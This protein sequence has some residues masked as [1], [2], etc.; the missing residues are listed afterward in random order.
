[1]GSV[2]IFLGILVFSAHL[3][4]MI[5]SKKKIPDVLL[6]L[7]IGVLIG[8]VLN[9][10]SP[11]DFGSVGGVFTS[12]TLVVILFE[13]GTG[14]SIGDL[15][16]SWRSTV[17]LT[18]SSFVAAAVVVSAISYWFGND[19]LNSITIG[20]IL[21]GT[22]S[23]VVIPLAQHL[24]LST[25]TKTSLILESALT[26][27]LCIV[28]AFAFMNAKLMGSGLNVG[29]VAGNV[30][31]SFVLA[32]LL[33]VIGAIVW[34]SLLQ[35]IRQ[36]RNSMFLT[37]A[38]LFIIYGVA[39][40]LG[41]SGAIASL[42]FGITIANMEYFNFKFLEKY[43][44]N[45]NLKL[46]ENEKS[47]I[48]E[49]GFVLKTFFFVYIG[50]SIPFSDFKCIMIGAIITL[51]LFVT[52]V[53][54]TIF[55]SPNNSNAFDKSVI[56]VM[57]P[58]GLAAAVLASVPEQLGIPGGET[59]KY[60]TFSVVFF[61]ILLCSVFILL[62]EKYPRISIFLQFFFKAK[63]KSKRVVKNATEDSLPTNSNTVAEKAEETEME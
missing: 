52:R 39:E 37:P 21:A 11:E 48:S 7:I 12:I 32:T 36:L 23:A 57:V 50:L 35:K 8:P 26:D 16:D 49:I 19:L 60:I 28:F 41:Y 38:Y 40:V 18:A 59:I 24:K 51:A 44:K 14:I 6:L 3:F 33:G 22:S 42:A 45:K 55:F 5:F 9:F 1:M 30:L 27:V 4:S 15:R 2:L 25:Q 53:I 61:S 62:V 20:A 54:T 63:V 10:V 47:F 13:G 34:A 31:S 43:Q 58:K 17:K 29:K 56:S 46:N